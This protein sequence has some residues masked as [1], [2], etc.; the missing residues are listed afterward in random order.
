MFAWVMGLLGAIGMCVTYAARLLTCCAKF[1]HM[2]RV[3]CMHQYQFLGSSMHAQ[4]ARRLLLLSAPSLGATSFVRTARKHA[5]LVHV[6]STANR[7][8]L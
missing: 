2:V 7:W 3:K 4:T 5:A 8:D 6:G 1:V